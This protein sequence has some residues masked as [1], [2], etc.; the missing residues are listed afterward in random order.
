MLYFCNVIAIDD[1]KDGPCSKS[2]FAL[3][4]VKNPERF[5]RFAGGITVKA[6]PVHFGHFL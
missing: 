5:E 1:Q 2:A 6:N 4:K 3:G